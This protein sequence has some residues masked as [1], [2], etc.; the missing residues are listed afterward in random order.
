[1]RSQAVYMNGIYEDVLR[2]IAR[3]HSTRPEL[4]LYLQPYAEAAIAYLRDNPPDKFDPV[5]LYT[6]TTN[7]LQHVHY[8]ADIIRW[9][10]KTSIPNDRRERILKRIADYQ[11]TE[12]GLYNVPEDGI[13]RNLLCVVRMQHLEEPFGVD[14]LINVKDNH[15][16]P[17]TRT[18]PGGWIYVLPEPVIVAQ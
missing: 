17:L 1:M 13:S 18:R 2:D 9:E 12:G 7:D 8:T 3:V 10:D 11:P 16:L 15:P 4:Q 6:S 14:R 5:R